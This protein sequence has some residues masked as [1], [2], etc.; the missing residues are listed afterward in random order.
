[1]FEHGLEGHEL[2]QLPSLIELAKRLGPDRAYWSNGTVGAADNW[3]RG[4]RNATGLVETLE[5]IAEN[6][7]LVMLRSVVHDPV[8]GPLMRR[9][10]VAI[11]HRAGP[12]LKNDLMTARST[13]LIASPHRITPYH[14]D[15]DTNFLMQVAGRKTFH[16]FN[17]SDRSLITDEELERFFA[18]DLSAARLKPGR[19]G[20]SNAFDLR[21]GYGV[22]VPSLA[23]HWALNGPEVSI[24]ISFNFDLESIEGLAREYRINAELRRHGLSPEAATA[25]PAGDQV[26]RGTYRMLA[27]TR[28]AVKHLCGRRIKAG[29]KPPLA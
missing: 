13:I 7:S 14:I 11:L 8:L 6:D 19:E 17:Q 9:I 29:W 12:A 20:E 23:P 28:Q 5:G 10:H 22:H 4:E 18:G 16:V 3:A 27:A 25:E 15:S 2:L 21:A 26:R 1:M 24:A